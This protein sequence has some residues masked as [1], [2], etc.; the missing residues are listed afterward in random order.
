[1]L[2]IICDDS[3]F[4]YN[5]VKGVYKKCKSFDKTLQI[6]NMAVVCSKDLDEATKIVLD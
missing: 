6:V 2:E 4:R 3:P 5:E 1:M